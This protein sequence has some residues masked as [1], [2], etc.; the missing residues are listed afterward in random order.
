MRG[1]WPIF[2]RELFALFVTPL[3]WVA[4]TSF[5]LLQ[6]LHF[7]L[8]IVNFATAPADSM[9]DSGPVQSFFGQTMLMYVP[10]LVV[11]PLLTM[12]SFAEERRSGTIESLL[13]APV[14]SAGVTLAKYAAPFVTYAAMWAPTLLYMVV[15]L[16]QKGEI[17]WRVVGTSYATVLAIGGGYLSIGVM[18]SALSQSQLTAAVLSALAISGLFFFGMA[19]F[20]IPDGAVHDIATHLSVWTQMNDASRGLLD[21]RRLVYD[22]TVIA[23]PLFITTRA[24]DAWRWG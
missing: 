15:I 19:E 24:V 2:K 6:G 11:C 18:T 20:I 5:L 13:T 22:A 4:I 14:G 16:M 17:D 10:L 3:A 12:R 7:F 9:G 23:L 1:F 21:S 8:I